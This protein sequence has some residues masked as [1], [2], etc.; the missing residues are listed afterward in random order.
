MVRYKITG[1]IA[2]L[3]V[4][5]CGKHADIASQ[6]NAGDKPAAATAAS[7]LLSPEDVYAVSSDALGSGPS[8]TGSVQPERRADLRAEVSAVVLQVLKENG[9]PV[10]RGDLLVR[11]DDTSIRD[12]L[13]SAEASARAASQA[14]DQAQ[15]QY[16]RLVKLREAGMVSVN[17]VE[18]A[19]IKRD[20]A[21]SDFEAAK[22]RA[23]TARQQLQR[24]EA[25]AP[26]D[27]IVSDRKVSVGDTAQIGK[28]L[29]K[30]ID[31]RSMRFEGMVSA[32]SIGDVKA[33]QSVVFRIH[34]FSEQEFAGQITRLSPAANATTRQV[35]VLVKFNDSAKPPTMAGLYAEGRVKTG[36]AANLTL[37]ASAVT[38]EGKQLIAWRIKGHSLQKVRLSATDRDVRTGDFIFTDGLAAGDLFLRH[39]SGSL[40]DGQAVEMSAADPPPVGLPK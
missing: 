13:V 9:D 35:E 6:A 15:R 30:V 36:G 21:Q 16:Q 33:G 7:L 37:P 17:D 19:E 31:P 14:Y 24:T 23:V 2:L 39:P 29:V 38:A 34:G 1:L 8:I 4:A 28:E 25:R 10:R 12:N 22:T 11:L 27:G 5:G 32:D 20:S 40:K 18:G 26:F 3:V